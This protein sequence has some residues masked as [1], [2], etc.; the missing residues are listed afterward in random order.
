MRDDFDFG[1]NLNVPHRWI[2]KIIFQFIFVTIT[3]KQ[4]PQEKLVLNLGG[5]FL[6]KVGLVHRRAGAGAA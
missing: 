6:Q 1:S 5:F 4:K 3:I 2:S